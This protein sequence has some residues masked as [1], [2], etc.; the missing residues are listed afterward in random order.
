M[1]LGD[2]TTR[3]VLHAWG[4]RLTSHFT[5]SVRDRCADALDDVSGL[6]SWTRALAAYLVCIGHA[7]ALFLVSW[8]G[9]EHKDPILTANNGSQASPEF[10]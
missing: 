5:Q 1:I 7:R 9:V 6:L 4:L 10:V 3:W 8:S 2:W